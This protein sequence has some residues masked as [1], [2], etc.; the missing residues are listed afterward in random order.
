[1]DQEQKIQILNHFISFCKER[2]N[3]VGEPNIQ[4]TDD[5]DWAVQHRSFG[6]YNPNTDEI[7]VYIGNRN[8]ADILRT[9]GHELVHEKQREDRK[10]ED[11]SGETG[12][13]VE[14]EANA[15]AGILM[16]DYGKMNDL[17][18]ESRVL[19]LKEVYEI[20]KEITRLKK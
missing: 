10:I 1:M 19:T 6:S 5:R 7:T 3:I 18:Y 8:L 9:L 13:D 12:S 15:V 4:F 20:E 2:L 11:G 14:N 16:R 17:I